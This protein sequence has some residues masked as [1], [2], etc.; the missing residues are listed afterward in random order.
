MATQNNGVPPSRVEMIG[1][2]GSDI[3][4]ICPSLF[5]RP[6]VW[7]PGMTFRLRQLSERFWEL[8]YVVEADPREEKQERAFEKVMRQGHRALD[9]AE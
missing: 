8:V 5:Q 7:A 1:D 3:R 4:I 2:N 9:E 6:E